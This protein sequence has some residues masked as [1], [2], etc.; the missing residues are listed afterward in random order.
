M[1]TLKETLDYWK[2]PDEKNDPLKYIDGYE[3]TDFLISKIE[4]YEI[5]KIEDIIELGCNTAR[6][7]VRLYENKYTSLFGIEINSKAIKLFYQRCR[8]PIPIYNGSL[9][10]ILKNLSEWTKYYLIFTMAVLCHIHPDI[11]ETVFDNM[12]RASKKYI[13]TIEDEFKSNSDRHF[14]RNY[15]EVF[16]SRGMVQIESQKCHG[17]V[18][19]G[20]NYVYR[21]FEKR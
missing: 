6:N 21:M 11:E 9:D 5:P 17:I 10:Y 16:E 12:V 4:K 2:N 7:L 19:L 15:Q 8:Y 3:K 1:K 14:P 18:G 20:N 13:L